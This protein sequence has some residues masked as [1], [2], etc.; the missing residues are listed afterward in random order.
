ME[1]NYKYVP[2]VMYMITEVESSAMYVEAKDE[3]GTVVC[4]Q[5]GFT[6]LK[7]NEIGKISVATRGILRNDILDFLYQSKKL[8]N[9]DVG[10]K[11]VNEFVFLCD[12]KSGIPLF[13]AH[14]VP[15]F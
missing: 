15:Q 2:N 7:E 5:D 10:F 14:P 3:E 11:E 12:K 6:T 8:P 9:T 4:S 13:A 1:F